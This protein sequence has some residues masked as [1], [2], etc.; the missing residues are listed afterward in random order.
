M[1]STNLL[2]MCESCNKCCLRQICSNCSSDCCL[3][4]SR[5]CLFCDTVVCL[6]CIEDFDGFGSF[7]KIKR[8]IGPI[9]KKRAHDTSETQSIEF[10]YFVCYNEECKQKSEYWTKR[11]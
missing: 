3:R 11:S 9:L 7:I 6:P 1:T 4:C 8:D 10:E 2:P 5:K